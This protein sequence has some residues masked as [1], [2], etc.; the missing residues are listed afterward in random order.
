MVDLGGGLANKRSVRSLFLDIEHISKV[1]NKENLF[2]V[3]PF[4]LRPKF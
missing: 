3:T 2:F 4:F 1:K